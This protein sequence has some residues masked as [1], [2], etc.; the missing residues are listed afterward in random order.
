MTFKENIHR[1]CR[2]KGTSLTTVVRQVTNS[3]SLVTAINKGSLP[4]EDIM[5][6]LAHTLDCSI[7][8]FFAN[9]DALISSNLENILTNEEID[10]I[11]IYRS[12]PRSKQYEILSVVTKYAE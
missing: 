1:I 5:I 9:E 3:S 11:N 2:E 4:K 6:A 8:D 7:M 10:I 12:L